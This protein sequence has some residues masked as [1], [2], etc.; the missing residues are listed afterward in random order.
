MKNGIRG[1]HTGDHDARSAAMGPYPVDGEGQLDPGHILK[2]ES[3]RYA[4]GLD[5]KYEK[6]RGNKQK[7]K[8]WGPEQQEE[9][10]CPLLRQGRWQI[11]P[12]QRN[13]DIR[14]AHV[15]CKT[16]LNMQTEMLSRQLNI[17]F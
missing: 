2:A 3:E 6:T 16:L 13:Q 12:D 9:W 14:P 17:K 15:K 5:V 7:S 8:V 10:R 11:R 4:D 1:W